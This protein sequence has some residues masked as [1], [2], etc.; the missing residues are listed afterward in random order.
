MEEE[1]EKTLLPTGL[2]IRFTEISDAPFLKEWLMHESVKH[3]FPMSDEVEIEDSVNRWIG[4]SRYKCS[5]TAVKDGVPC[6]IATLFL[7]PYKKL[8]HQCE[9]GIIVNENFRNQ[10]IGSYLIHNLIH[11]AKETFKIEL[12]HLQVYT[13]NPAI[14]LYKRWGFKEFGRQTQWIKEADGRYAG[15]VFMERTI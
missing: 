4:F 10:R 8:V 9:F 11:L 5:L 12:L 3:W 6:G 15:R 2:E 13:E 1:A 7:Q 14:N